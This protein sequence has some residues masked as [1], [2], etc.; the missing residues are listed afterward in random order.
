MEVNARHGHVI[1][2]VRI[3]TAHTK[4]TLYGVPCYTVY[5]YSCN[6]YTC[7]YRY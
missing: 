6:L 4:L 2:L 7:T 3:Y 1:N 5:S